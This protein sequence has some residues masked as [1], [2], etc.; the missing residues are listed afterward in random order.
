MILYQHK[1]IDFFIK[2]DIIVLVMKL[3]DMN[4]IIVIDI[5]Q[6]LIVS[7]EKGRIFQMK[8][9]QSYGLSLCI[10]GQIKYEMN[11][12]TYISNPNNAV[13]LPQGGT[14]TLSGDKEGLFPVINFKCEN[15]NYDEIIVLPLNNP[16][17]CI[18]DFNTLKDLFLHNKNHH[19]IYSTFYELLDKVSSANSQNYNPLDSVI[20]YIS[21]NIQSPEL[22]NT[23]LAK[24]IDISEVYLR[25]LFSAYYNIT[26]KQYILDLRIR[27][28]KQML[29]DTPFSVVA[30]SEECGFSSV[31]HFCRAFKQ[32]VG[33]TP[34]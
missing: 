14:Y 12:K 13:L 24:Q 25:K 4:N 17:A 7:S 1:Y 21:E 10:S 29:C 26:P 18:K 3:N 6:P 34:T 16:Q 28:A 31:Y 19:K 23:C 32:R 22:S 33:L 27:K 5:Q 15:F 20:K 8:N 11:N 9:R 2:Y 30:I